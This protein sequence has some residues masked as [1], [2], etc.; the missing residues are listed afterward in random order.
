[1]ASADK[2][3]CLRWPARLARYR[4]SSGTRLDALRRLRTVPRHSAMAAD[5]MILP[6]GRSRPLQRFCH[7][8]K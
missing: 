3:Y 4:Y 1:M 8:Q 2:I 6:A 7:R 5:H